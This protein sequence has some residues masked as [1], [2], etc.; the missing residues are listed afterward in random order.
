M[1]SI[2]L[3]L[4]EPTPE[5][6]PWDALAATDSSA[7]K[8]ATTSGVIKLEVPE[9]R[10]FQIADLPKT[11]IACTQ[12]NW[13]WLAIVFQV[14]ASVAYVYIFKPKKLTTGWLWLTGI[15]VASYMVYAMIGCSCTG[16]RWCA[17][18][19]L[20]NL[21]LLFITGGWLYWQER[22]KKR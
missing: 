8:R 11:T 7:I 15:S 14:A 10:L 17:F 12:P 6:V 9:D 16:G 5:R 2:F 18:Y 22:S 19:P 3:A 13:W 1:K 4:T 21:S 20:I